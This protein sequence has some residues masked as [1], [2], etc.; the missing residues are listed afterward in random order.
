LSAQDSI[1]PFTI[2][3]YAEF[4]YSYDLGEPNNHLRPAFFF[5][6]NRHSEFNLNLAFIKA[7]Y[8]TQRIRANL[9]LMSGTYADYNLAHEGGFRHLFEANAGVKLTA[10][11]KLWLDVGLF[12][13]HLG[14]ESA[15]GRECW[16][17]TRS[18]LADN[19]P[20]YETG[21]R[22]S[23]TEDNDRLYLGLLLLNGWQRIKR[24][25]GNNTPAFGTQILIKPTQKL[26]FNWSTY[27]GNEQPDALRR[28]RYFNNLYAQWR[29]TP[30]LGITAG[31]DIG[32]EQ[33]YKF[34]RGY[35][36]WWSPVV[37]V[38]YR[39]TDRWRVAAR[40]EYYA[41]L[42]GVIIRAG[43][44]GS[45]V[46]AGYSANVDVNFLK[47]MLLRIE[48]RALQGEKKIFIKNSVP[49]NSNYFLTA[50]LC[51]GFE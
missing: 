4:Y 46:I 21:V 49:V 33:Q 6:H 24:V 8:L 16:N 28:W 14:F 43:A 31:F 5:N 9:A 42:N 39:F 19:S 23:Y 20:Y 45:A 29:V 34:S 50:S 11:E 26:I 27:I 40:A 36:C 47:T 51:I 30:K 13:S 15:I 3:G 17:L 22:I 37:I 35:N 12:P 7:A 10:K 25:P 2:S 32:F 1:R 44:E 48:A 18:I 38:Q 41:D